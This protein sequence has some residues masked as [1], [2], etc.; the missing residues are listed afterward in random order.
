[1]KDYQI[2]YAVYTKDIPI[3]VLI[4]T[5]KKDYSV[6][7][8]TYKTWHFKNSEVLFYEAAHVSFQEEPNWFADHVLPFLEKN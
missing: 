5:G 7:P 4:I 1:M 3:P 8:D 2:D 6:G